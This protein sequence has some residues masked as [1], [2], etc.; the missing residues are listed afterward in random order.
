MK[1]VTVVLAGGESCEHDISIITAIHAYHACTDINKMIVYV[2]GHRFYA[3]KK[4]ISPKA[5]MRFSSKGL[6][7]VYFNNGY[8][9]YGKYKK[10]KIKCVVNC[11]HGGEGEGGAMQGYLEVADVP[12][13]SCEVTQSGIFMDKCLS[14]RLLL[15]DGFSALPYVEVK[16]CEDRVTAISDIKRTLGYPVV[17]KPA[18]LGSSI[19]ICFAHSDAELDNGLAVA[20]RFGEKVLVEKC[21]TD[22]VEL[23]CAVVELNGEVTVSDV[24]RVS[25]SGFLSFSEKYLNSCSGRILPADIPKELTSEIQRVSELIYRRYNLSGVVRIDFL[26]DDVLYV[27][28]VNTIPGSLSYYLFAKSLNASRL[29]NALVDSAIVRYRKKKDYIQTFA[30]DVLTYYNSSS[31]KGT[32]SKKP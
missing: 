27:N 31:V 22:F 21:L 7:E 4:L 2:R 15:A 25:M 17:I 20:F 30:S 16:E 5:Y 12:Y 1:T 8:L 14:K 26:Y 28:E 3:G 23:N 9:C 29:L 18:L 6:R 11:M 24:E 13:T 32:K 19:G 10:F